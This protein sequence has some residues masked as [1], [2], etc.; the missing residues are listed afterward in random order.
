MNNKMAS[1]QVE[2]GVFADCQYCNCET[3]GSRFYKNSV[4]KLE[5]CIQ[6]FNKNRNLSFI[7]GLGDFIDRDFSSYDT[8]L[9]LLKSS[10]KEIYQVLGNHD[11]EVEKTNFNKVAEKLNLTK[12]YYSFT[13][14]GWQF[15]F[16]NGNEITLQSNNESVK[17][18]AESLIKKLSD[19]N[20]PN[21]KTWNG[22][23]SKTQIEWLDSELNKAK[24]QN[25]KVAIFCHYPLLPLE[26]HS[27]WNSDEVLNILKNYSCVKLYLNGH[28]H[29]GNYVYEN[30]IHFVTLQAM[31]ETENENSFAAISLSNN[32]IEIKGFGREQNRVLLIN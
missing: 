13:K 18:Q 12:T 32:T 5:T 15:I 16:L 1:A 28:N 31:V 22:G 6:T 7:V 30:G 10:E 8:I 29:H 21:N 17:I 3:V 26:A 9:P 20:K 11:F 23:I 27:L 2:F 25:L 14:N 24:K 4:S 19:N